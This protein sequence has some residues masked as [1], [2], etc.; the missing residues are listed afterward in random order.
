MVGMLSFEAIDE[1][2]GQ[3]FDPHGDPL[4]VP[5]GGAWTPW[6]GCALRPKVRLQMAATMSFAARFTA[7]TQRPRGDLIGVVKAHF[8]PR[9]A[10]AT[11]RARRDVSPWPGRS[12]TM[13]L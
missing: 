3:I 12:D 1:I 6:T 5:G 11:D 10:E 4:W 9:L 7:V 13:G 2:R 8:S